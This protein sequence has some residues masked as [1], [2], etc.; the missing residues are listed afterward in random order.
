MHILIVAGLSSVGK[1][2]FIS[3]LLSGQITDE[4]KGKLPNIDD[5]LVLKRKNLR[6]DSRRAQRLG[7]VSYWEIRALLLFVPPCAC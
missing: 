6:W 1:K 4:V 7:N 5:W 2:T 3:Q